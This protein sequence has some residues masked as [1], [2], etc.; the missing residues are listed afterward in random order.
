MARSLFRPSSISGA[1]IAA[2]RA[3]IASLYSAEFAANMPWYQVLAVYR[4][5]DER[6]KFAEIAK[7]TIDYPLIFKKPVKTA[8]K[9]LKTDDGVQLSMFGD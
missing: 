3:A 7:P 2:K 4:S 6:G 9:R 8:K 5:L 1:E